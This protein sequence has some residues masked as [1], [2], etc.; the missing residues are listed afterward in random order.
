MQQPKKPY[1]WTERQAKNNFMLGVLMPD[2]SDFRTAAYCLALQ[3]KFMA[4]TGQLKPALQNVFDMCKMGL[5]LSGPRILIE[6]LVGIAVAGLSVQTGFQVLDNTKPS[7][8]LLKNCQLQLEG[9]AAR[10]AL[11]ID[12]TTEKFYLYDCIQR[13]FTDDGKGDG[14]VYGARPLEDKS[15]LEQIV[16]MEMTSQQRRQWHKLKRRQTTGLVDEVFAYFT[17]VAHKTPAQLHSTGE[18]PWKVVEEMTKENPLVRMLMPAVGR[19]M[20]ISFRSKAQTGALI[21]TIAIL[22]YKAGEGQFPE[23]LDRLVT[24]GYLS[25]LPMDPFSG[26]QLVYKRV[27]S[28]F[29]LYS[30]AHDFDDDGGVPSKWGEGE[31]GGDQV[32]WPV[33]PL[34]NSTDKKQNKQRH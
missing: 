1:Y 14:H 15:Y 31:Q 10:Q 12:F 30:F 28:D 34:K 18:D 29:M 6:Q 13:L 11:V 20:E 5:H 33:E 3:A 2:L 24:T 32:F 22:R 9:L 27:D 25:Q 23:D 21:T 26:N 8:D 7:P 19:V 4:S 17:W 16:G